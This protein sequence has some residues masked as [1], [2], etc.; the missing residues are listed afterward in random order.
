MIR[1]VSNWLDFWSNFLGSHYRQW[2]MLC[3]R[4]SS[5]YGNLFHWCSKFFQFF[6]G[7]RISGQFIPSG[8]TI[9][10]IEPDVPVQIC[11]DALKL[12][13][14]QCILQV[15][16][17]SATNDQHTDFFA[18][19][20]YAPAIA[21]INHQLELCCH[22][23]PVYRRGKDDHIRCDNFIDRGVGI[24]LRNTTISA[25]ANAASLAA[26]DVQP[27]RVDDFNLLRFSG[28]F[29]VRIDCC[30]GVSFSWTSVYNNCL[31]Y[32]QPHFPLCTFYI[33]VYLYLCQIVHNWSTQYPHN[34]SVA[35]PYTESPSS[36]RVFLQDIAFKHMYSSTTGVC[37]E[38]FY[39]RHYTDDSI[40]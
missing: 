23:P 27:V 11:G 19:E 24:I 18:L 34:T 8:C 4:K 25:L 10:F 5:P 1:A 20:E 30:Q 32:N 40:P 2:L 17:S 6:D 31:Q 38:I 29:N 22:T 21:F 26:A 15:V 14:D 28:T 12:F 39:I 9:V 36:Y 35:Y 13:F 16:R 37:T 7:C 33:I 3:F